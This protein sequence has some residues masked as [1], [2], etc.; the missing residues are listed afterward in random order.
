VPRAKLVPPPTPGEAPQ[1]PP[2]PRRAPKATS[3]ALSRAQALVAPYKADLNEGLRRQ[4]A[5]E[6]KA[7][8]YPLDIYDPDFVLGVVKG[9]LADNDAVLTHT[10]VRRLKRP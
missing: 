7:Q 8:G 6:L 5:A 2:K 4:L 1:S 10:G 3:A 9:F